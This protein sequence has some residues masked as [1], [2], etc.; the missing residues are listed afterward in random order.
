M[1]TKYKLSMALLS[2]LFLTSCSVEDLVKEEPD[3]AVIL[4]ANSPW[5]FE[6]FKLAWA[7]K[8]EKDTITDE[9]IELEVNDSYNNLEFTFN[10]DGTGLTTMPN[11]QE[12]PHTWTWHF[13]GNEKICFDNCAIE[14][15][16]TKVNLTENVLSFDLT[17]GAPSN[18]QGETIIYSGRYVFK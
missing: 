17:A 6:S 16:F 10:A 15:S 11:V 7:T 18:T 5:K 3:K 9:E 14:D 1:S 4:T 12:E 2:F 8:T 13:D